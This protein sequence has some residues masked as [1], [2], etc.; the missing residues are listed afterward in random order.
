MKYS[1]KILHANKKLKELEKTIMNAPTKRGRKLAMKLFQE[2]K[3]KIEK[4]RK[5]QELLTQL[6]PQP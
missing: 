3:Q 4:W 5:E 1:A 2:E 6:N